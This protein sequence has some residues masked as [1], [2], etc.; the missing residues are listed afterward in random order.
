MIFKNWI[1]INNVL[2]RQICGGNKIEEAVTL[3]DVTS[4]AEKYSRQPGW[5]S[6]STVTAV[7]TC[8]WEVLS[9]LW[10]HL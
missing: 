5:A 8:V 6:G 9:G 7:C 1:L 3:R 2:T 10:G 4:L